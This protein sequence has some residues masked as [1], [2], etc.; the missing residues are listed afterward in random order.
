MNI[1]KRKKVVNNNQPPTLKAIIKD[2]AGAMLFA[3]VMAFI[4]NTLFIQLYAVP[5]PSMEKT[6][7]W[8]TG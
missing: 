7:W 4:I 5:T 1:F 3:L 6:L 2:W 8:E